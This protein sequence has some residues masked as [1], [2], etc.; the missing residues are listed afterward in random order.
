METHWKELSRAV[1][2][3][4]RGLKRASLAAVRHRLFQGKSRALGGCKVRSWSWMKEG[5]SD[6]QMTQNLA[7]TLPH[8]WVD[9]ISFQKS[10]KILVWCVEIDLTLFNRSFISLT[11]VF[12]IICSR[13]LREDL[14]VLFDLKGTESQQWVR[15]SFQ[16][17]FKNTGWRYGILN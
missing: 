5:T 6:L 3:S 7:K 14:G 8:D 17:H 9:S 11:S 15:Y 1:M 16:K 2:W 13:T 10:C 12:T 4:D